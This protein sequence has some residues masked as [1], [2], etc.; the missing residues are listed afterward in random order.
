MRLGSARKGEVLM[1]IPKLTTLVVIAAGT[2]FCGWRDLYHLV[3]GLPLLAAGIILVR[4][5]RRWR[6]R[7][8][9]EAD[10]EPFIEADDS[11]ARQVVAG[12]VSGGA[13]LLLLGSG[14]WAA[15]ALGLADR[16]S[17]HGCSDFFKT[18]SIL[19]DGSAHTRIIQLIDARLQHPASSTCQHAL[20]DKKVRT[21]LA[22]APR[23]RGEEKSTTIEEAARLAEHLADPL[24]LQLA[25]TELDAAREEAIAMQQHDVIA[26]Q[27]AALA[28]SRALRELQHRGVLVDETDQLVSIRLPG[29][30]FAPGQV[31]LPADAQVPLQLVA[32]VIQRYFPQTR[33]RVVGHTDASGSEATNRTVSQERAQHVADVLT[34]YGLTN[35]IQVI[36]N[37][38][39]FPIVPPM[40]P[41]RQ[42]ENRRVE[43]VIEK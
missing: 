24:L 27:D 40:A 29:S 13:A 7:R 8:A 23:M 39:A 34:H 28:L 2:A 36:G 6:T 41:G 25:H 37:G 30:V 20:V 16:F 12:V 18:L 26:Q 32:N 17:D 38:A 4:Q 35:T 22:L 43:I 11:L 9:F 1:N 5:W 42:A 21:L 15:S 31:H 3:V 10:E 33:L 14:F 19:E